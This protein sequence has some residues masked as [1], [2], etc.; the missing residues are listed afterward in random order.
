MS[1]Q[2]V[3]TESS[4]VDSK[5]KPSSSVD[6]RGVP[7]ENRAREF[8]RKFNEL[9]PKLEAL[10]SQMVELVEKANPTPVNNAEEA[11]MSKLQALAQD[12][13]GYVQQKINAA[14]RQKEAED[15]AKWLR[16]Q[17]DYRSEFDEEIGKVVRKYALSGQPQSNAEAAWRLFR[18]DNPD[19]FPQDKTRQEDSRERDIR[20]YQTVGPGR[21]GPIEQTDK[22]KELLKQLGA[23]T[24]PFEKARIL[25][26]LQDDYFRS[27]GVL[28]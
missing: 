22:R 19:K 20:Q 6:E 12:P 18:L 9:A 24:G 1:E 5:A 17:K 3:K 15:A 16:S 27:V 23:A 4:V 8:E 14:L 26:E 25:G 28:K 7:W 2:D 10:Q 21:V 13:E 11:R